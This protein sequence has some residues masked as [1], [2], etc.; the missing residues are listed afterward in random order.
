MDSDGG[1]PAP[2]RAFWLLSDETRVAILRA[3]WE[4]SADTVSF[5]EIRERIG[6]PNSGHFNYYIDKLTGHFLSKGEDGYA[7]TQAGREVVRAVL[8]GSLTE[9]P[10]MEST[11]IDGRCVEC[12]GTSSP[13]T[14]NTGSSS[15]R[16]AARR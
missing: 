11:P 10:R 1:T 13:G 4:S 9:R 2:D 5:T 6:N 16:N 12:G 15:V 7:L 3:V 8:A 14:T